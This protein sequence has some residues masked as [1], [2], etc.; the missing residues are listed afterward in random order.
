[1]NRHPKRLLAA[2]SNT[3]FEV[4]EASK[5]YRAVVVMSSYMKEEAMH[6]G[7]Q[8]EKLRINPYFVSQKSEFETNLKSSFDSRSLLFAGR[9]IEHKGPHRLLEYLLPHLE[10]ENLRLK[11]IGEG[12]LEDSM[13]AMVQTTGMESRVEFL[14]WKSSEEVQ[15]EMRRS[16][17]FMFSSIYPEAFGI[18]GIEAMLNQTPVIGFDVGGASEWLVENESGR[19]VSPQ[20]PA[21]LVAAVKDLLANYDTYE[22]IAVRAKVLAKSKFT[23]EI[24][25][26]SLHEL[27]VE[28]LA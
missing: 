19:K 1:M 25:L 13:R 24:H 17:L 7:I 20:D 23:P 10:N 16:S 11:F 9:L 21:A 4:N 6:T 18:V 15:V 26:Q 28:A 3:A 12:P 2:Y 22:R 5:K 27:F 8:A 14:G